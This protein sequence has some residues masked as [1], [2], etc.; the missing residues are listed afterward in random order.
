MNE[1]IKEEKETNG[2]EKKAKKLTFRRFLAGTVLIVMN[3]FF[4]WVVVGTMTAYRIQEKL[5]QAVKEVKSPVSSILCCAE[6]LEHDL[7]ELNEI[8][9][10]KQIVVNQVLEMRKDARGFMLKRMPLLATQKAIE[11]GLI[12]KLHPKLD[13]QTRKEAKSPLSP[14]VLE[15]MRLCIDESDETKTCLPMMAKLENSRMESSELIERLNQT[16]DFINKLEQEREDLEGRIEEIG[17]RIPGSVRGENLV[18]ADVVRKVNNSKMFGFFD[19]VKA[20][21]Q[22]LIFLLTLCMGA[23]GSLLYIT[24]DY[25][26]GQNK[27]K[28]SWYLF[29]PLLGM[30]TA[31][32][33]YI[34]AIAG[35]ITISEGGVPGAT[36]GQ[37]NPYFI[38]FLAII[39]GL[40]SEQAI[41]RIR[42]MGRTV[43]KIDTG[44]GDR[45]RWAVQL[46]E[47]LEKGGKDIKDLIPF[48]DAT[49]KD[50]E[51]WVAGTKTVPYSEQRVVGTWLGLH[52]SRIFTDIE[53]EPAAT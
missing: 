47:V 12:F 15:K 50:V 19:F 9:R 11:S 41:E 32:A 33:V 44:E 35:Q 37:L 21:D 26:V 4:I 17:Q 31:L 34:L 7:E 6:R 13:E 30:V 1:S 24:R 20:S 27:R 51:K 10:A 39:S 14:E 29:R 45:E 16:K 36:G 25:L 42:L 18:W 49:Y 46:K 40:L 53:P 2:P 23:L 28:F 38:S 3:L 5:K 22:Q 8:N 43:L 48:V 52:P